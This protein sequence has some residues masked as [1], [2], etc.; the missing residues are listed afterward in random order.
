MPYDII[1]FNFHELSRTQI[2]VHFKFDFVSHKSVVNGYFPAS[3]FPVLEGIFAFV[4]AS[5]HILR[6]DKIE[7]CLRGEK[8]LCGHFSSDIANF[9]HKEIEEGGGRE[10]DGRHQVEGVGVVE[11][12]EEEHEEDE[13]DRGEGPGDPLHHGGTGRRVEDICQ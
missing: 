6:Q 10:E 1:E 12:L 3:R 7:N 2:Y 8:E 13:D 9:R 5:L 4:G 11:V